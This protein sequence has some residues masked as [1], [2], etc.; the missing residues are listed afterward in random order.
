MDGAGED[1]PRRPDGAGP[2]RRRPRGAGV[3]VVAATETDGRFQ[4][5]FPRATGIR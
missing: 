2:R 1:E 5:A 4:V 3:G